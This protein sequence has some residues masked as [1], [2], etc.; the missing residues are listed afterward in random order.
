MYICHETNLEDATK[1]DNEGNVDVEI[2]VP[3]LKRGKEPDEISCYELP[4]A[5]MVKTIHKG[6]YREEGAMYEKLFVWLEKN[7]KTIMGSMREIYLNDPHAVSEE[8]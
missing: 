4:S 1:A 6:P 8:G 7:N 5:K 2:A 3:I